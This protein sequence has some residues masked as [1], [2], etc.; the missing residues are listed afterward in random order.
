HLVAAMLRLDRERP[1]P[2]RLRERVRVPG[3]AEEP[4]ALLDR[5]G[6]RP[7]LGADAV[8]EVGVVEE[9]LAAAAVAARVRAQLEV[10]GRRTRATA[11]R[12]PAG[13]GDPP[14]CG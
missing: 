13:G 2:D 4:V 5:L 8:H 14:M 1:R 11:A 7:V 9:G 3:E 12:P 10:A 6:R